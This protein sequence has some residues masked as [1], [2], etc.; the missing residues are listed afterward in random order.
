M[1]SVCKGSQVTMN[2][3]RARFRDRFDL[4][5]DRDGL[6]QASF[7]KKLGVTQGAISHW[8]TGR[9]EPDLTDLEAI[10][11][12]LGVTPEWLIH[13]VGASDPTT[14]SLLDTISKLSDSQKAALLTVA[15]AL[16]NSND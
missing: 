10:A 13:G 11:N 3:W 16:K 15:E 8:L 12:A 5:K 7:A 1:S 14:Q 2:D 6:T 9:R 4:L